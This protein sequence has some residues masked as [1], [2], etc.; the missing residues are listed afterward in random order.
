[1][2]IAEKYSDKDAECRGK[3]R[4]NN[5]YVQ[6]KDKTTQI[7]TQA[8]HTHTHTHTHTQTHQ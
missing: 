4:G 7:Q 3:C 5:L 8:T 2:L 1:M 6:K